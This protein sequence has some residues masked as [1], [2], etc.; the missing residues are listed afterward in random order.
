M[1]LS[2]VI[3]RSVFLASSACLLI[4]LEANIP[5]YAQSFYGPTDEP[6]IFF[7]GP[8]MPLLGEE[9]TGPA[10]ADKVS[11]AGWIVG[12]E[13]VPAGGGWWALICKQACALHPTRLKIKLTK[14][15]IRGA[16]VPSQALQWS[17]LP[18]GLN[19]ITTT[20]EQPDSS[21]PPTTDKVATSHSS[22]APTLIGL[23]KVKA[24]D[25]SKGRYF[26]SGPVKTW[27]HDGLEAYPLPDRIETMEIKIPLGEGKTATLIP[28]TRS[29]DQIDALELRAYGKR[30]SL[31]GYANAT[32]ED[33]LHGPE[34]LSWAGDLDG[35]GKLDLVL[36]HDHRD[37]D[38]V[39]Y[40]S[41][42]AQ[43]GELVGLAG[44]MKYV[45]PESSER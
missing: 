21:T 45:R 3:R 10:S 15:I 30:Q 41:T 14:S 24:L 12:G 29:G 33:I 13:P 11:E 39:L 19:R 9:K 6:I 36:N 7:P 42:L 34:V 38:S 26:K 37:I 5:S 17:P 16:S 8:L 32:P 4:C 2:N 20:V 1:Q 43:S 31:V 28:R 18:Y 40:L 35:D 44:S 22:T 23:F 27:L 25:A